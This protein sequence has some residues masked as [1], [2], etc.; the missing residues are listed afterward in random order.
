MNK[1][2]FYILLACLIL[3]LILGTI[4]FKNRICGTSA[5]V[6][7]NTTAVVAPVAKDRLLIQDGTA[8]KTTA[9]NHFDF[10]QSTYNYLTPLAAGVDASLD[11]TAAYLKANPNRSMMVTGLYKEEETNGSVFPNLGLARANEIKKAL[12]S[13]GVP[14]QQLLTGSK[15][16]GANMSLKDG[17]LL[18]GANFSF[19]ETTDDLAERLAAIKARLN[20]NPVTIYF[21]T[22]EQNVNLTAAQRTDFSDLVFYLDNVSNSNLEVGGHTDN[23][24]DLAMNTRLSR[25]RAE[26]VQ[27][28]LTNNGL[29]A[30]RLSAQG[31]GPNTPIA[32]NATAAGRAKNRRVE[33]RLK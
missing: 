30:K 27:N 2:L 32:D 33:V 10:N 25:K 23:K 7:E 28:Y 22:G 17:V 26:F 11:K 4:F 19:T 9:A 21:K 29:D 18:D 1:T 15:L 3:W 8:F 20:A 6:K 5:P 13:L 24:G 12:A 31:Y 16:L 14:A